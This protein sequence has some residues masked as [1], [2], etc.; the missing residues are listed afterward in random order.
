MRQ[1]RRFQM[2]MV[3]MIMMIFSDLYAQNLSSPELRTAA[4]Y[5]LWSPDQK[6][7]VYLDN[8]HKPS[9]LVL[10]SP[11]CPM[12]VN[13]IPLLK[14]LRKEYGDEIQI[15]GLIPGKTYD[16]STVLNFSRNYEMNFPLYIDSNM[17]L[18]K[19]LKAE[20]TPESYLFD[21]KGKLVYHGAIDNWLT[22]LGKKRTRA[23]QHY[24]L[25]AI[26]QM[27]KGN[28]VALSYI[29]PQGCLLNEY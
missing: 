19:Y 5:S 11:E 1:W 29:K 2:L 21:K 6:S 27:M 4:T 16:D 22:A 18:C 15:A 13:Y 12:C 24:L 17:Q 9:L 8:H 20:V 7:R 28:P 26:E 10:L 3:L 25:D 23:D 14:K